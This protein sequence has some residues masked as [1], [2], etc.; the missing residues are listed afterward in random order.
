M[1]E[2][3]PIV[4]KDVFDDVK[5]RLISELEIR[6]V[7]V[8][9]DVQGTV[10]MVWAELVSRGNPYLAKSVKDVPYAVADWLKGK[11]E[12]GSEWQAGMLA[13]IGVVAILNLI[14]RALEVKE[15]GQR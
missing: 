9:G 1:F 11:V 7:K 14:N 3:L 2:H 5:G 10:D 13:L 6:G 4:T 8:G 12:S 15:K